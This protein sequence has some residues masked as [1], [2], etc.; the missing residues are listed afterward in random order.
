MSGPTFVARFADGQSTRMSTHTLLVKLDVGRGMRLARHAYSSRTGKKP[1]AILEAHFESTD[2][3]I[4][5]EYTQE[6]LVKATS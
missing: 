2:G 5:A 4:L 6:Q 1:P 3:E